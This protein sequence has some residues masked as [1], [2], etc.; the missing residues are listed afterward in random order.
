MRAP[1]FGRVFARCPQCGSQ[2]K[3]TLRYVRQSSSRIGMVTRSLAR[4]V[5]C[6]Y[7]GPPH[8]FRRP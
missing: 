1:P 3:P 4:C 7:D 2:E 6:R 5:A 8:Q